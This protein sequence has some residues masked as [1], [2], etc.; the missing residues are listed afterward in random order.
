MCLALCLA[1]CW[2]RPCCQ[3]TTE[4]KPAEEVV[5]REV[6]QQAMGQWGVEIPTE[7]VEEA[8]KLDDH[9]GP[10]C[11]S[12]QVYPCIT[13]LV[14][15][16]IKR[17]RNSSIAGGHV[18]PPISQQNPCLVSRADWDSKEVKKKKKK[19]IEVLSRQSD[20]WCSAELQAFS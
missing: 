5:E 19:K 1:L 11:C 12:C 10:F 18:Q 4:V 2:S 3:S 15:T 7:L 6:E 9:T 13:C 17:K 16:C 8:G 14:M 20:S